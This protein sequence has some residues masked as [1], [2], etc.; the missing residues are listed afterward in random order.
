MSAVKANEPQVLDVNFIGSFTDQLPQQTIF[1]P[2]IAFVGRSNVG[3]STLI[4]RVTQRRKIAR[5]SSTPGRTRQVNLFNVKVK[6]GKK[7]LEINLTDLPGFGYAK[8]SK[9][10]RDDFADMIE[11]YLSQRAALFTVCILNDIRREPQ[12]EELAVRDFCMQYDKHVIIVATKCDKLG[13]NELEKNLKRLSSGFGLLPDD[14]IAAGEGISVAGLWWR[15]GLL[16]ENRRGRN[17]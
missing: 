13:R 2:E 15:I 4:N 17:E 12:P 7:L 16:M 5:V 6:L 1:M 10:E 9:R 14:V 3:K 8:V 11:G